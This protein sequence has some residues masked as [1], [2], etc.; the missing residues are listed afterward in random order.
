VL[1]W[2]EGLEKTNNM[3]EVMFKSLSYMYLNK[4]KVVMTCWYSPS[5]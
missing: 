4:K 3:M 2:D 5:S 1:G